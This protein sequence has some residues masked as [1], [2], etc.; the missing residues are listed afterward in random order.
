VALLA[1]AAKYHD[2]ASFQEAMDSE[3]ADEWLDTCQY[4][5]DAPAKNG[6]WDLVDLPI[7][8]KAMKSKWV[9]K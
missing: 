3:F 8:H 7:G 4:K 1:V 2:P 6:T 5:M 9:F